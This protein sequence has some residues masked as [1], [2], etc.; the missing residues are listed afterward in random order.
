MAPPAAGHDADETLLH[1]SCVALD[2]RAVLITGASGSGKSA[3]ALGLLARGAGLVADDKTLLRRAGDDLI[4]TCPKPIRGLIE[5]RG[6]GLLNAAYAGP[7]PVRLAVD[8][9]RVET[10]RL[11]PLRNVTHLGVTLPL[12]HKVES[13]HFVDSVLIYLRSG[14]SF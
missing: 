9:D 1:A 4:A 6:L 7:A 11:P 14:R 5:A 10:E 2:G 13:S 12:V 8:L 3:L